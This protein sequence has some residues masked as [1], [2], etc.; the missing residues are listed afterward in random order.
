VHRRARE[1]RREMERLPAPGSSL[2]RSRPH[3]AAQLAG[4]G[5]QAS[6][7]VLSGDGSIRLGKGFEDALL[8]LERMPIQYRSR[9]GEA[10]I[11]GW[12]RQPE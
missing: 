11:P 5:S 2:T 6:A 10:S 1:R 4:D 12:P 3:Q 9:S 7:S 8:F